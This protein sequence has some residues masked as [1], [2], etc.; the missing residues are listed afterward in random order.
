MNELVRPNALLVLSMGYKD[1]IREQTCSYCVVT[2]KSKTVHTRSSGMVFP[3]CS[4]K[5]SLVMRCCLF[6]FFCLSVH[7]KDPSVPFF[8][9][10]VVFIQVGSPVFPSQLIC[11]TDCAFLISCL[12]LPRLPNALPSLHFFPFCFFPVYKYQVDLGSQEQQNCT[13]AL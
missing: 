7:Y 8:I 12:A 10:S 1:I 9:L 4:N 5:A 11:N 13:G 6:F 3:C 2:V